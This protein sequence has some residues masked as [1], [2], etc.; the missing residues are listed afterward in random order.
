M[1]QILRAPVGQPTGGQ[2][3]AHTR[4]EGG[5]ELSQVTARSYGS[6]DIVGYTF[7]AENYRGDDLIE[8]LIKAELAA[9]AA[10]DMAVEDVLDQIAGANAIDREDEHTFDT[11]DFPKV[12]FGSQVDISD[13]PW[14]GDEH[15]SFPDYENEPLTAQDALDKFSES[16]ELS[17]EFHGGLWKGTDH[18]ESAE[19]NLA[20]VAENAGIW[21]IDLDALG[22]SLPVKTAARA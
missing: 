15:W 7:K 20:V 8:D 16:L 5:V 18:R 17:D 3:A 21:G 11:D 6:N 14:L 4:S 13:A 1:T 2:F 12:I 10:R 22:Y 9:P 19:R